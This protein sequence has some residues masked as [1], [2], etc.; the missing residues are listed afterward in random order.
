VGGFENTTGDASQKMQETLKS[1]SELTTN[2]LAVVDELSKKLQDMDFLTSNKR[3][4]LEEED[5]SS[6]DI[7]SWVPSGKRSLLA[8]PP[9]KLKPNLTVA[10]DGS[11]DCKTIKEALDQV[12]QKS[13]Q[14]F[15][16]YIKEGLY[17]E[18]ISVNRSTTNVVMY[19]DGPTK[20]I[21][22]GN[23]NFKMNLTT[24]DTATFGKTKSSSL[25]VCAS[26]TRSL[27][28]PSWNEKKR[29]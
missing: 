16:I 6:G 26:V 5:G 7:P 24:K 15:V 14:N 8:A 29:I 25:S 23:K 4:L 20:T 13:E 19:G 2:I 10:N 22:S 27:D 9:E 18:Y 17:K 3:R 28:L 1:T 11:G 21:I 12:P